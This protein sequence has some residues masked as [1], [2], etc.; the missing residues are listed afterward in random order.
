MRNPMEAPLVGKVGE[1]EW[2][3]SEDEIVSPSISWAAEPGEGY[4]TEAR[5]SLY[6][7]PA[8]DM[9]GFL[10]EAGLEWGACA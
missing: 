5:P 7:D 1:V 6:V 10:E 2:V 3:G 9:H 8:P 4:S